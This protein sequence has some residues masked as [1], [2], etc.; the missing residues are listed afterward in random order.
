MRTLILILICFSLIACIP[1]QG[2]DLN[3]SQ[4][5]NATAWSPTLEN[6]STPG[7]TP[8]AISPTATRDNGEPISTPGAQE[9]ATPTQTNPSSTT[10]STV[11]D[12]G[13]NTE[14]RILVDHHSLPLFELIPPEYIQRA[15][16]IKWLNR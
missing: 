15:S 13:S 9:Q 2:E 4:Q 8:E 14:Q 1:T 7:I 12:A 6:I 5:E 16:Q 3:P 11:N 10:T